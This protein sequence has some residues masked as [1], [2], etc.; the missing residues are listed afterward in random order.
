MVV[1]D[2]FDDGRFAWAINPDDVS[3]LP[4]KNKTM[5]EDPS[6][7]IVSVEEL[8]E[9]STLVREIRQLRNHWSQESVQLLRQLNIKAI[10]DTKAA[11]LQ[12][13]KYGLIISECDRQ[14]QE[15]FPHD[16]LAGGYRD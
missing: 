8:S 10:D 13:Y 4:L 3:T 14:L 7:E 16:I 11:R 15:I 5:C 2:W 1:N 12:L 9:M 6:L